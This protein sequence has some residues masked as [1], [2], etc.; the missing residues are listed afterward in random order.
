M[1]DN[2]QQAASVFYVGEYARIPAQERDDYRAALQRPEVRRIFRSL[3][4]ASRVLG[5]SLGAN[6]AFSAYSEGIRAV[7][8]FLLAKIEQAAPGETARLMLDSATDI[9]AAQRSEQANKEEE[10]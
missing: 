5:P 10:Y 8:L 7:G 6:E 2:T 1:S 3:L 9:V 4:E